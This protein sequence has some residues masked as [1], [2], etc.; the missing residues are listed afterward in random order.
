MPKQPRRPDHDLAGI[1]WWTSLLGVTATVIPASEGSP[2][3]PLV[4]LATMAGGVVYPLDDRVGTQPTP[5]GTIRRHQARRTI[6]PGA[7][8]PATPQARRRRSARLHQQS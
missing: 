2:A 4:V 1:P 8:A 6:R 5:V 7:G 3:S